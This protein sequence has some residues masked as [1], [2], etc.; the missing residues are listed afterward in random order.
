MMSQ[1][2]NMNEYDNKQCRW[3]RT[4]PMMNEYDSWCGFM[5]DCTK[6]TE[7]GRNASKIIC[8]GFCSCRND[9]WEARDGEVDPREFV[10]QGDGI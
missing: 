5:G 4:I 9:C 7:Q 10:N 6:P 3:F 2:P 8:N 1:Q